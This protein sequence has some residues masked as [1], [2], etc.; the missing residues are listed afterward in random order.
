MSSDSSD[1]PASHPPSGKTT[2]GEIKPHTHTHTNK[3]TL[4]GALHKHTHG[5]TSPVSRQDKEE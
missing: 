4:T 5:H 3:N 1:I 2:N